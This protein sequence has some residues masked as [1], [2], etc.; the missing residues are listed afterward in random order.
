LSESHIEVP[1]PISGP[2]KLCSANG[3]VVK[4]QK[5]PP[6]LLGLYKSGDALKAGVDKYRGD[7]A[8][9][10][11]ALA[12][13]YNA[14]SKK[15]INLREIS[16]RC[17]VS[18]TKTNKDG[19]ETEIFGLTDAEIN[20]AQ[21][22]A[23][24]MI[25]GL[26][27]SNS[28]WYKEHQTKKA[29]TNPSRDNGKVTIDVDPKSN[30]L[31]QHSI[32][33]LGAIQS[34]Y[35]NPQKKIFVRNGLMSDIF[36][37]EKNNVKI[38]EVTRD[39]VRCVLDQCCNFVSYSEKENGT[40]TENKARPL[41]DVCENILAMTGLHNHLPPL[42]GITESPYITSEGKVVTTPGYNDDTALYFIPSPDYVKIDI[43]DIITEY[44]VKSAVEHI[45]GLFEDF[46]FEDSASKDNVF[47]AILTSILRP[48]INGCT[49]LYLVDKP[50]MGT[51]GS[52]I[53]EIIN[54]ISTGK[55]LEPS[56]APKFNDGE[57]WEKMIVSILASG[58][59]S[60][61]FDNIESNFQS[62]ALASV[63]TAR[64]K[65]CRVLGTTNHTT[66]GVNVNWMGNGINLN[67][68]GD[69]P[70]RIYLTRI[71][72]E[73]ARPQMKSD[74]KIPDIKT[75][76]VKHRY[77]YLKDVLVIAKAY[78]NAG[79]PAPEWFDTKKEKTLCIPAMGSFEEWRNYIG[80][81]MV[82][83]NKTNFLGN[84]NKVLCECEMQ[85][86]EDEELLEQLLLVYGIN[87]F[88]AKKVISDEQRRFDSYI[89][90]YIMKD[91][92][93]KSRKLGKHFSKIRG[94][95]FPSGHQLVFSRESQHMQYWLV[96]LIPQVSQSELH[97]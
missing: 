54:R 81:I 13:T 28:I 52:L 87:D 15:K 59:P 46:T 91:E 20:Q 19:L 74:F 97:K 71:T 14:F 92:V 12:I 65:K 69:L 33:C 44:D 35:N 16:K 18:L 6:E 31:T 1:I 53:C 11:Y 50:Q 22:M 55:A 47:A 70:R 77:E 83:I 4:Q 29:V 85:T 57:E 10:K 49:P 2:E 73:S 43:P 66:F 3:D 39:G 17:H 93:N 95:V 75:H 21:D 41:R 86:N 51:G 58:T 56:N 90:P 94:R 84:M 9:A 25:S 88:N 60:V 62:A 8:I 34:V 45:D 48:T 23:D 80:G 64:S 67:V 24:V 38:S 42:M 63:L 37:D 7:M 89:P 72:T 36:Y 82:F 76:T 96:K 27:A 40:I 26:R 30:T 78:H 61:C 5:V 79:R 68:Q 32:L